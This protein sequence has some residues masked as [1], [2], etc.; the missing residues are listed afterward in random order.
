MSVLVK[1]RYPRDVL[2][3]ELRQ[4]GL[5]IS[6]GKFSKLCAYDQGPPIAGFRANQPLYE[7][8]PALAWAQPLINPT[9]VVEVVG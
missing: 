7:W 8:E 4:H 6:Y 2:W 3:A 5:R 1:K 9:E